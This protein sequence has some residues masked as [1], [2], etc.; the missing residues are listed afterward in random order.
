M[1]VKRSE[2]GTASPPRA[3]PIDRIGFDA[4]AVEAAGRDSQAARSA[5]RVNDETLAWTRNPLPAL[6]HLAW[7]IVV[8]MLSASLMTLVDTLMVSRLGTW[9]LA[10]VGLGGVV[11]FILVCFPMGVLGGV[12]ILAS[13][14]IGAGRPEQVKTFLGADLL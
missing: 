2:P 6:L 11:G 14:S 13:Q 12:K 4:L 5:A 7:P 8:S 9:A 1:T 3:D 10:G